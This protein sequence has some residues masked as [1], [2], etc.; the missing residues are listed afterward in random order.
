VPFEGLRVSVQPVR[1]SDPDRL[2][3]HRVLG[4]LGR[5]GM[6]VVYLADGPLGRLAI[7][8]VRAELADDPN[9]RA[10]FQRELAACFRVGG[11]YAARLLDFD[12]AAEQPWLATEF[13]DA[14]TLGQ[15]VQRDGTFS[16]PA[17]VVLG[18]GLAEALVEIH[19][20]GLVHRDLKPSNVM[21]SADGPKVIDFGVAAARDTQPLTTTGALI[22]TP[23]WLSPE[24]VTTGRVSAASDVF[25]WAG[26]I[27]YAAAGHPPFGEGPPE[28]IAYR[29]VNEEP[30][31]DYDMLAPA[32][33]EL[34][35]SALA[36][37]PQARPT[38]ELLRIELLRTPAPGH[39]TPGPAEAGDQARDQPTHLLDPGRDTPV[40]PAPEAVGRAEQPAVAARGRPVG[41][42]PATG[43]AVPAKPAAPVGRTTPYPAGDGPPFSDPGF[44]DTA[45]S[46]APDAGQ[47]PAARR[48]RG[49]RRLRLA[50]A[51]AV[52]A[53]L[54]AGAT[55]AVL[56]RSGEKSASDTYTATAPWR[57]QVEDRITGQDEGCA[58]TLTDTTT[59]NP[60]KL[61]DSM[62]GDQTFQI[63]QTGAFRWQATTG[64]RITPLTGSG[65]ATLPFTLVYDIGD[66]AAFLAPP[67]VAVQVKDFNGGSDCSLALRDLTDGQDVDVATAT[68][69]AD[70]V[71]LDPGG[72][73]EV[74]LHDPGC[75][76]RISAAP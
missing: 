37:E 58:V 67:R 61:P 60:V 69:Q 21:W 20:A 71:L 70:T 3:R 34:V 68:T 14:P 33:R 17:Q 51:V 11:R 26:L 56:L 62:Y 66:S 40:P 49:R 9:F 74:Y 19:S 22:G 65:H 30:R 50:L 23:G 5:G 41:P 63:H 59:G 13:L 31:V 1:P 72:R 64:C 4:R 57:L 28:A 45:P 55:A 43:S 36:R 24:Q 48:S 12:I 27:C 18:T 35:R 16:A 39:A 46:G 8:V 44:P 15:C 73:K 32:L 42:A 7:K 47:V 75:S 76:V 29:I 10:R 25:A 6:G 54:A 2:G 52:P 38:A 53:L